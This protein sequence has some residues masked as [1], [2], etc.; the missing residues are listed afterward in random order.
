MTKDMVGDLRI[1]YSHWFSGMEES[2]DDLN[3]V[4]HRD[5]DAFT[6]D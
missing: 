6:D 3:G 2:S 5:T 4:S 1:I